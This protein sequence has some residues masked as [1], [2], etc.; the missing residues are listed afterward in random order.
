MNS[1]SNTAK[2]KRNIKPYIPLYLLM[3]PAIIILIIFNYIPMAGIIIA[4]KNVSPFA[5]LQDMLTAPFVGLQNFQKFFQSYYFWNLLGNTLSISLKR[6]LVSF[7]APIILALLLNELNNQRFKKFVQTVSY[8]P[9]FISMVILSGLLITMLTTNGGL[10]N[11]AIVALGGESIFFLGDPKYFQGVIVYSGLWKDVGW[12]T[13]IYLAAITGVDVA[14]HEAA[15]IDGANRF[16]RAMFI[17]LP[18]ISSIIVIMLILSVGKIMDAG[19]EQILLLY[20]PSVYGVG[21]II[22]TYVYREGVVNLQY[23]YTTAVG[24]FKSVVSLLLVGGTNWISNKM[25]QD[26]IW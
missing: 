4:F 23:S 5:S 10:V 21:D 6:L 7:P 25:G 2:P 26:G 16:H 1:N 14:Q 17:T 3:L 11:K 13:I 8:M 9:H 18:S 15:T 20:S 19:F 22:D 24:L 12:N